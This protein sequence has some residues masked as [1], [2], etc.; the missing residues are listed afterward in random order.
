VQGHLHAREHV[1]A[2]SKRTHLTLEE[3]F[4]RTYLAPSTGVV[5]WRAGAVDRQQSIAAGHIDASGRI[6]HR[7]RDHRQQGSHPAQE[8]LDGTGTGQMEEDAI[9]VLFDLRGNFEEGKYCA[10]N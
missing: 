5:A 10:I 4:S 1:L 8:R 2:S 7:E 6:P 3:H 9:L